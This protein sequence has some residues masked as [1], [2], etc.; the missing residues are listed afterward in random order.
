[1][2]T[3]KK[4]DGKKRQRKKKNWSLESVHPIVKKDVCDCG[5]LDPR[6]SGD[7]AGDAVAR[8]S[9]Q[10]SDTTS[11]PSVVKGHKA[12]EHDESSCSRSFCRD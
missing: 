7:S 8:G 5:R 10:S 6:D 12:D 11:K 4:E 2:V 1:M 9:P 3:Q